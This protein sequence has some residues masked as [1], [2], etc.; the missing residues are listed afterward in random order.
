MF[1]FHKVLDKKQINPRKRVRALKKGFH[2]FHKKKRSSRCR[3]QCAKTYFTSSDPHSAK[4]FCLLSWFLTSHL[5][6]QSGIYSEILSELGSAGPQQRAPDL[7]GL[8]MH[9]EI[10]S[11]QL[12]S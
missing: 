6:I 5:E 2:S 4:L 12:G 10:R 9:T 1:G 7:S 11:S 8:A 3:Q